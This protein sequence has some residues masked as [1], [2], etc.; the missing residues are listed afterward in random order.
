MRRAK[1]EKWSETLL[2]FS[3]TSRASVCVLFSFCWGLFSPGFC[4]FSQDPLPHIA[5]PLLLA[6]PFRTEMTCACKDSDLLP[7]SFFPVSLPTSPCASNFSFCWTC[8]DLLSL[9]LEISSFSR[10]RGE[11]SERQSNQIVFRVSLTPLF[12]HSPLK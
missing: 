6:F 7:S 2:L 8:S 3:F 1:K 9:F 4:F 12:F 11:V 5:R 10:S